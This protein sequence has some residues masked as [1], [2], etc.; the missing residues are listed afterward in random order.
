MREASRKEGADVLARFRM[1]MMFSPNVLL[2][3]SLA[4]STSNTKFAP[5]SCSSLLTF[6]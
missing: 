1:K 4:L 5:L 2:S 3:P 6:V